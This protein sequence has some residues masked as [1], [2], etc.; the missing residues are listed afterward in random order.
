MLL[1]RLVAGVI[2]FAVVAAVVAS[3]IRSFVLP[4]SVRDR[5]AQ[6]VF[7]LVWL[8]FQP[9]TH[10]GLPYARRDRTLA[11][12]APVSLLVL[13]AAWLTLVWI[14][15]AAMYWALGVEPWQS[16]LVLSGS[17]LFT[18][19]FYQPPNPVVTT[20]V[21]SEAALGL[22]LVALLIAYLP[23]MYGAF[24]RRETAVTLLEVRA[25]SPPTALE[26]IERFHRLKRFDHLH[27]LWEQWEQWFAE[28]EESH[29]SL[30]ALVFFRSPHPA[31]SWVN[32]AGAVMDAA[33]LAAS[34][35]DIPRDAQADLC[36][37]AG[38]L[39]L[40]HIADF[41]GVQYTARPQPGDPISIS[42]A[43]FDAACAHLQER[44]VPVRGDREQA[45]RDFS[46]WR[47]NYD[48]VLFALARIT[49]APEAPWI[50]DEARQRWAR[51]RQPAARQGA[52]R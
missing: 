27:E 35:L 9:F 37:R 34:S 49:T 41:F 10:A 1:I 18:L 12:Y 44:N 5:V 26:L 8:V 48:T 16:T 7:R 51:D 40:R 45:W 24:A 47:V 43:E 25:G 32:A 46:G 3:A 11:L 39:A 42:R 38:Y 28:L 21:F 13:P 6:W 20:L 36:I 23:T 4:R 19:G 30:A 50:S 33:A 52:F 31:R 17:S 2:G 22:L 14:G 15:Y 29:T